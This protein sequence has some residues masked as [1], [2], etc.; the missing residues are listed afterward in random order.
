ML[1]L[2]KTTGSTLSFSK[3]VD[4]VG[5]EKTA[6]VPYILFVIKNADLVVALPQAMKSIQLALV[7]PQASVHCERVFAV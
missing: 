6:T 1:S 7:T 2:T 3:E 4:F 5:L